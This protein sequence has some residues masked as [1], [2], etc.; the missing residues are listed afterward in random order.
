MSTSAT[1][2]S[3]EA[4]GSEE[5]IQ[6][7]AIH[8]G[9]IVGLVLGLLSFS[10]VLAADHSL[11]S[12]LVVAPIP[13]LGMFVSLRSWGRIRREREQYTGGWMAAAG[14]ALSLVFLTVGLAYGGYVYAT[15]VREGYT[16]ISFDEM[17]PDEVE[18]RGGLIVPPDIAALDGKQVYIKGYIRPDSVAVPKGIDRFLL[19]RD[20]NQCCFGDLSK[21]K[22]HDQID[23]DMAG[24]LRVDFTQG[25][26]GIGGVL[27]IRPENVVLG[28]RAPVFSLECQYV[29]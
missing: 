14:F 29:N 18:H 3:Y 2:E 8:T 7:R 16:R 19:V 26:L 11:E 12:C 17:K 4:A 6:Y 1:L 10:A 28:P 9:A 23:V 22:Y 15:E 24:S 25:V 20:N 27:R 13:V 5:T 21:I